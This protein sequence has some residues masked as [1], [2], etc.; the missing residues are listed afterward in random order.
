[1]TEVQERL[2]PTV[3][4]RRGSAFTVSVKLVVLITVPAVPVTVMVYVP[5]GVEAVVAMVMVEE[6]V[7]LQE[8][9]ENEAVAPV[10]RPDA[11][12]LTA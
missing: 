1:M 4:V 12:K 6:Q 5:T 7:G 11:E 2:G 9:G 10:G 3:M 8:V